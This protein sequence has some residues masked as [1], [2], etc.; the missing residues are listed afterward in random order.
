M[1]REF[2]VSAGGLTLANQAVTLVFLNPPAATALGF[3]V[4]RCWVGQSGSVVSAMQR[5]QLVTQGSAFPTLVS[6][7]PQRLHRSDGVASLLVGATTGAAG[8]AGVNASAEGAGSKV[9]LWED[10]F[11][12][13][14]GW[15][16]IFTP[17]ERLQFV[18]GLA[19]GFGLHLPVAPTS[20][21]N[22]NCGVVYREI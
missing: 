15:Q 17:E 20:L 1:A 3:E 4:L 2:V 21:T 18:A 10:S 19:V 16:L 12:V 14:N 8:T 11:N 7:T 9:I 6:A 5:V 13:L 22:W